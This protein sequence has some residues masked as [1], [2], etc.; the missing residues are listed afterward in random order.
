MSNK[1]PTSDGDQEAH[2]NL[3]KLTRELLA[4]GESVRSD[5]KRLPDGISAD[6]L[7]AFANSEAGGQILAG[8]D[9]QVV[10]KAQI[11]VVRGC[12]VSDATVLQILNKA[13]SCIPPVSIDVYIENLDDKP[14]LRVEVPPSLTK[15]YCTPRRR[16]F[17][18]RRRRR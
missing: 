18:A 12:D 2:Q 4:E 10:D 15:P 11:G 16:T 13:V 1:D 17:C 3:S 14:I 8:V 7:V 6:D 9:E 5:F